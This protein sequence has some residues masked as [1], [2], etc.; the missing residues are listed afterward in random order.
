MK[1]GVL[2]DSEALGFREKFIYNR[3]MKT[4]FFLGQCPQCLLYGEEH[5]MRENDKYWECPQCSLQIGIENNRAIIFRHRGNGNFKLSLNQPKGNIPF[6]EVDEMSFPN[7]VD[8][9]RERQ[10][11]AYLMLRVEQQPKYSLGKLIDTYADFK[12]AGGT[13]DLYL[14]Q[15]YYFRIDFDNS[16]IVDVLAVRDT[17]Y[18]SNQYSTELL[19]HFLMTTVLPQYHAADNSL[20]AERGMSLIET[21]LYKKHF[22]TGKKELINSNPLYIKQQLKYLALDVIDIIYRNAHVD[23][24][25]IVKIMQDKVKDSLN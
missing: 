5:L 12:F 1:V 14:E 16:S 11:I 25:E 10:L 18:V 24:E 23:P 6:Q 2:S 22:P 19:Y 20:L 21:Y 15:S 4:T 3:Y 13:K 8:I 9:L 7:G 17:H